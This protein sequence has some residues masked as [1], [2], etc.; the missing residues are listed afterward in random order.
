ML[1]LAVGSGLRSQSAETKKKGRGRTFLY[2]HENAPANAV[3][4]MEVFPEGGGAIEKLRGSPF[5]ANQGAS[6]ATGPANTIAYSAK[7]RL[8]F[9]TGSEGVAVFAVGADGLPTRVPGAPFGG[10]PFQGAA[11][12]E[13]KDRTFVYAAND[14]LAALRGFEA[15]AAGRL[16][17]LPLGCVDVGTGPLGVVAVENH[18]FVASSLNNTIHAFTVA[19]DGWR[20]APTPPSPWATG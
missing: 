11:V 8:L 15:N 20:S 2:L 13:R 10:G 7:K 18:V 19:N 6:G 17:P 4:A 3:H 9:S 1:A 14:S 16:R 12:V 5:S